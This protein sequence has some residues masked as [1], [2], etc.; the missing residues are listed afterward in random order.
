MSIMLMMNLD[1]DIEEPEWFA[2]AYFQVLPLYIF[3]VEGG[4]GNYP[5]TIG[6][7]AKYFNLSIE[8]LLKLAGQDFSREEF[9]SDEIFANYQV[10]QIAAWQPPQELIECLKLFVEKID[11]DPEVYSRLQVEDTYFLDGEFKRDLLELHRMAGWAKENGV[12][13]IRLVVA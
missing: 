11:G 10:S 7:L 13:K 5:D 1:R 6:A 3:E 8:P 9:P 4:A 2:T 12:E